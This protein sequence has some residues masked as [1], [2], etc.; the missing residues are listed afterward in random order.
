V[1][2][3]KQNIL[4]CSFNL[5]RNPFLQ[6]YNSANASNMSKT[7]RSF[8]CLQV[9]QPSEQGY[10]VSLTVKFERVRRFKLLAKKF[11]KFSTNQALTYE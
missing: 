10:S 8:Y 7:C 1:K 5:E 2:F 11:I 4:S 3:P 9:A 6:L